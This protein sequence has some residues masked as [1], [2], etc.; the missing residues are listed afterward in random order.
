M[1]TES[2][3]IT[4]RVQTA[5][6][7][8]IVE[9]FRAKTPMLGIREISTHPRCHLDE[10]GGMATLRRYGKRIFPEIQDAEITVFTAAH[11]RQKYGDDEFAW[12]RALQDGVLLIGTGGGPLDDHMGDGAPSCLYLIARFLG[13]EDNPELR[14]LLTYV[15]YEDSHGERAELMLEEHEKS[16][17]LKSAIKDFMF[18][19]NIKKVWKVC[20]E[21]QIEV[22][23][24][25]FIIQVDL[26]I[27]AKIE[28]L[29]AVEEILPKVQYITLPKTLSTIEGVPELAVIQSDSPWAMETILKGNG[30][31]NLVAILQIH[32]SGNFQLHSVGKRIRLQ[33]VAQIIREEIAYSKGLEHIDWKTLG[34]VG[35][36][37]GIPEIHFYR[38]KSVE[39]IFNGSYTQPDTP[40]TIDEFFTV[41]KLVKMVCLGL[42]EGLFYSKTQ[43]VCEGGGCPKMTEGIPCPLYSMGLH[44]CRKN[45]RHL[46]SEHSK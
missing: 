29:K 44:R 40:P 25:F 17:S 3:A 45:R 20:E 43:E 12:A 24:R 35:D 16:A 30:R 9:A 23:T 19:T 39:R 13:V 42:Q 6:I 27:K 8:E 22:L 18:A 15:N 7:E 33:S 28:E 21:N 2:K 31:P 11:I 5:T 1:E 36:M 38:A 10:V 14:H 41:E 46:K 34:V 32:S 37:P 26:G 4:L